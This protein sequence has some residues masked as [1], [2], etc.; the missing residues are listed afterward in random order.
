MI[1]VVIVV[2]F[3]ITKNKANFLIF[4]TREKNGFNSFIDDLSTKN[5]DKKNTAVNYVDYINNQ[6]IFQ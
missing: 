5:T 1:L 4:F 3:H 6:E 2:F